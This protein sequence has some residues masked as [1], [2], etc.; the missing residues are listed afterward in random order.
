MFDCFKKKKGK[1]DT[2]LLLATDITAVPT[3]S[4]NVHIA[5]VLLWKNWIESPAAKLKAKDCKSRTGNPR[6]HQQKLNQFE[7]FTTSR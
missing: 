5:P 7:E 3:T 6:K 4:M 1:I 2:V